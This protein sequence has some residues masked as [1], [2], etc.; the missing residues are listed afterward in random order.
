MSVRT[1]WCDTCRGG[2][3]DSAD[4]LKC[5][6]CPRK[7]HLECAGL[8]CRPEKASWSC[9]A[10]EAGTS[11]RGGHQLK[12][13]V[14]AV[15]KAH[16]D[17]K[18]RAV[19]FFKDHR[20]HLAPFVAKE[21]LAAL[22]APAAPSLERLAIDGTEPYINATLRSY[23]IEGVNWMLSQYGRGTGGILG[24]EMG[25]GKT[26]QTLSFLSALKAANLPGPHLVVTPLAVLQ[27]WANEM[28]RFTPGLSFVKVHG[29]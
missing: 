5:T 11:V 3:D 6:S 9:H 28:K 27:N 22:T 25:L 12:I 7:F 24:D 26:I 14:R 10:C 15:K 18:A 16:K 29:G 23:Q 2:S 4:L 21:R 20:E 17:I 1:S 8:T 13:R 19:T